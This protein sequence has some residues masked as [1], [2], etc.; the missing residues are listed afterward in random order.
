MA[1]KKRTAAQRE[2]DLTIISEMYLA[3]YRQDEI[4]K[5]IGVHRTQIT[6]DLNEIR[7]R[8]MKDAVRKI[9]ERKGEELARLDRLEMEYWDAWRKSQEEFK[10]T[11]VKKAEGKS[12]SA[13]VSQHTENRYGDPRFLDGALK[14]IAK[15]CEILGVNAPVKINADL[16][17]TDEWT[18][19]PQVRLLVA[20][21]MMK[22][23]ELELTKQRKNKTPKQNGGKK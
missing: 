13:E 16:T 10:S 14:C 2:K 18:E 23:A 17:V 20:E 4:A 15:R 7:A 8:W 12:K 9:D 1:A 6:Y 22:D 19:D 21:Q 3:A 5:R 11:I